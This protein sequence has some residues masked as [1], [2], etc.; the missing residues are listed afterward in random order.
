M[1]PV[2]IAESILDNY[3]C[4]TEDETSLASAFTGV[5]FISPTEESG[6]LLLYK[7]LNKFGNHTDFPQTGTNGLKIICLPKQYKPDGDCEITKEIIGIS[8]RKCSPTKSGSTDIWRGKELE[9]LQVQEGWELRILKNTFSPSTKLK[10]GFCYTLETISY[11]LIVYGHEKDSTAKINAQK[12]EMNKMNYSFKHIYKKGT[13]NINKINLENFDDSKSNEYSTQIYSYLQLCLNTLIDLKLNPPNSAIVPTAR[14]KCTDMHSL[15]ELSQLLGAAFE[16]IEN[17]I[18]LLQKFMPNLT[19][20]H[21]YYDEKIKYLESIRSISKNPESDE[22]ESEGLKGIRK[23]QNGLECHVG[24]LLELVRDAADKVWS[25]P[26]FNKSDGENYKDSYEKKLRDLIIQL[27]QILLEVRIKSDRS[28]DI[29][30]KFIEDI[31]RDKR[32]AGIPPEGRHF[33]PLYKELQKLCWVMGEL[34]DTQETTTTESE[35]KLDKLFQQY[36]E[37]NMGGDWFGNLISLAKQLLDQWKQFVEK[38]E[39]DPLNVDCEKLKKKMNLKDDET[40]KKLVKR[41]FKEGE[42][43]LSIMKV[44]RLTTTA[45]VRYYCWSGTLDYEGLFYTHNDTHIPLT[46]H[47]RGMVHEDK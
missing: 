47:G 1:N 8:I 35:T 46:M 41:W 42:G 17:I 7:G 4:R 32:Y 23:L 44:E 26:I 14:V 40:A 22:K 2:Q 31:F 33:Y 36:K 25:G 9:Y 13:S 6:V 39:R 10:S 29:I 30:S 43:P 21:Q 38:K 27:V 16:V 19:E 24:K 45:S 12:D 15:Q 18:K 5:V 11:E 28:G 3:P 20:L 37:E 34:V